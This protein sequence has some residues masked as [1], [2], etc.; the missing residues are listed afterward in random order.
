MTKVFSKNST[1]AISITLL[2]ILSSLA[3]PAA[4][5]SRNSSP[6]PLVPSALS[7]LQA[8]W[9]GSDGNQF[10]QNTNPQTLINSSNAQY[11]GLNWL[12]PLPI[13][14][15]ALTS[16][17]GGLG[18]DTAPLII[19]GTIY[20]VTQFDQAFALNAAN[21]NVLWTDVLPLTP[22]STLGHGTGALT[23]HLHNGNQQYTTKLF[24]NTPT[25]WIAADDQKVYAINALNGKYELNFSVFD[26]INT[27]AGNNPGA[28]YTGV[29]AS[30][31]LIDQNKGILISSVVSAF[32]ANTG[33][34]FFRGWNILV[35][36]PTLMWTSFCTPPQPGGN[37]PLDPNWDLKQVATMKGAQIFYPGPSYN[38]GGTMPS[39]AVV[40][41]K[42]LSAA[43][44]NATLYNDWGYQNQS[45]QCAAYTGNASTGG[46]AAGWGSPWLVGT[47]PTAGLA[48]VPTNN[49]DPYTSPCNPGPDLWSAA[50]LALNE[51][52]GAWVWGFQ[53]SA[54]ENWD[55]DCSWWQAMGNETVSGV[56]TQVIWKTC[57]NGYLYELNAVNGNLI[58]AYTPPQSI[59]PRCPYCFSHNPL[60][61]TEMNEAYFN[62][63]AQGSGQGTLMYP[64]EFAGFEDE[65]SYSPSLNYLFI[66]SQNVPLLA[67]YV[68]PNSTNY[69]TNSGIAFFPPT[70]ATSLAG[71]QNNATVTAVNAAT[72]QAVWTHFIPTQG[73]RGGNSNSGNV[74][75][76]TLSSGD[77][78]MLNAQTGATIK[79][80]YIGGPLNVL[81]SIGATA[82]GQMQ[83]I[84]PITAGLV[85]WGTG[86]PGDI[87]AFSL[88]NVPIT[89]TATAT[90]TATATNTVT[91]TAPGQVITTT[92]G[93]Q[94]ITTTVGGQ[95]ITTTVGGQTITTTAGGGGTVT[96]TSTAA[97]SG[98][99]PTT[100]YGV[101]AVA[102]LLAVSTGYL[103]LRGRKPSP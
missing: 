22:N 68:P 103:A 57:K 70:G 84:V 11:L 101:A 75:Y 25:W 90:A 36:P 82:G 88:Q 50:I 14:P 17:G 35:T 46:T 61:S 23:L 47:G 59:L 62:P 19:N 15:T 37:V 44:L 94:T 18:V 87:V 65:S 53:S 38:G 1:T 41:L 31:V 67:Y 29:G 99:D 21:G 92:V 69:K 85:S 63:N 32:A 10:N 71:T 83:V 58:W 64:S 93:G 60:N 66:I 98:V 9:I 16:V 100:L 5:A 56:N 48:F 27:V 30:N 45:P 55:Y 24:G 102:V 28:V 42:T 54:H 97:G 4:I 74:I 96:V 80:Y 89:T 33:R 73:Y 76:I 6:A 2:F 34:C 39:T 20:A 3:A 43:Q 81:A 79:D 12:F 13:H 7:Q 72:G 77:L 26:G 78:L 8:N 49:R 95:V 91:T 86:V 51:T 52:T 40:D